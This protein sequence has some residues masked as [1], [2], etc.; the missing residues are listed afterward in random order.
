MSAITASSAFGTALDAARAITSDTSDVDVS[1][2]ATVANL[3]ADQASMLKAHV[4]AYAVR[5]GRQTKDV[6]SLLRVGGTRVRGMVLAVESWERTGFS[7]RALAL[8]DGRG[9]SP[10]TYVTST[11]RWLNKWT[12]D[13]GVA[14]M[15]AIA[16]ATTDREKWEIL[17]AGV[18]PKSESKSREERFLALL[19]AAAEMI[20][21]EQGLT[22]TEDDVTTARA[23][24]S[25]IDFT[26]P[27]FRP[28]DVLATV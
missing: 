26:L 10:W 17:Q 25:E 9:V 24:W 13:E 18:A 3:R 22:L 8:V 14:L 1:A 6:A 20:T 28:A 27:T 7:T 12:T 2:L 21:S 19:A 5:S 16:A 4:V 23:T 11:T 15:D